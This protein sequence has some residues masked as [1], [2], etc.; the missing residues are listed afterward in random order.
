[1]AAR[2]RQ[3]GERRPRPPGLRIVLPWMPVQGQGQGQGAAGPA[4]TGTASAGWAAAV[5]GGA[6][7][8]VAV[9]SACGDGPL[10]SPSAGAATAP[11]E[12]GAGAEAGGAS[13]SCPTGPSASI[14]VRFFLRL[15]RSC[16]G[17]YAQYV[18]SVLYSTIYYYFLYA[19]ILCIVR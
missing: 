16:D 9:S 8:V 10:R 11:L 14:I 19:I 2:R 13:P 3:A 6:A 17:L 12:E 4:A 15:F 18:L 7:A 1:M 5:V